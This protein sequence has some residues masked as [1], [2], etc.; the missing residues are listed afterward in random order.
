MRR[1]RAFG[2][3]L[4]LVAVVRDARRVAAQPQDGLEAPLARL[5][6]DGRVAGGGEAASARVG[7][8]AFRAPGRFPEEE[9]MG[10]PWISR[11]S[12]GASFRS[13]IV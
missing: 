4:D 12:F 9:G 11:L 13:L 7:V 8:L 6:A 3:G 10:Y 2:E 1:A 5:V